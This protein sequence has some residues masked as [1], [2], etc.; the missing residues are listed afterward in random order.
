MTKALTGFET[1]EH[2]K[3]DR[4][5]R[6]GNYHNHNR[7]WKYQ[8]LIKIKEPENKK[9]YYAEV[10]RCLRRR[11][12]IEV[13][14]HYGNDKFACVICGENRYDCLSI[15]H[16]DGGGTKL[17]REGEPLGHAFYAQLKRLNYPKGFR[18]L[19]MNCQAIEYAK[20]KNEVIMNKYKE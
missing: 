12:K 3:R 11:T 10:A 17:K 5:N 7:Y 15:D 4:I 1:K 20:R 16:I 9:T 2:C 19:C 14:T 18:T 13:F 6:L 8:K